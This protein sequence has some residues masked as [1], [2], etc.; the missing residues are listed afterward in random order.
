MSDQSIITG[1][2]KVL[3][4]SLVEPKAFRGKGSKKYSCVLLFDK[5]DKESIGALKLALRKAKA[6][7]RKTT[8]AKYAKVPAF[9][10]EALLDGDKSLA[11]GK[12]KHSNYTNT[13]YL[14]CK[15]S[16]QP[17]ILDA[18]ANDELAPTV[19]QPGSL[20]QAHLTV[21][22]YGFKSKQHPEGLHGIT[23]ELNGLRLIQ[24][25]KPSLTEVSRAFK[26]SLDK[27]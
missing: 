11:K 18:L 8:W 7:G 1:K 21:R 12:V 14:T 4:V 2:A 23:W 3:F 27:P 20:V 5:A 10:Y 22:S 15:S 19:I 13:F 25:S 24:S 6:I 26:D 16:I 9:K 17:C